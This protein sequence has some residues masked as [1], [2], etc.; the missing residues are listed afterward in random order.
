MFRKLIGACVG[1]AMMGMAGT[2]NAVPLNIDFGSSVTAPNSY[3]AVANQAGFWNSI[4]G[5][6]ATALFDVSGSLSGVT[7]T[8]SGTG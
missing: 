7:L 3:G 4:T 2:A 8:L 6:G 5:T 1:L